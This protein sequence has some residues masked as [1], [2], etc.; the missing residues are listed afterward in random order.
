M[1][2]C[3]FYRWF[4]LLPTAALGGAAAYGE[5]VD[6]EVKKLLEENIYS[7]F[8]DYVYDP[9]MGLMSGS[10]KEPEEAKPLAKVTPAMV[11]DQ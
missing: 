4:V 9:I 10:G 5:F 7:P 1:V 6:P 2:F 11:C 3:E 8:Q